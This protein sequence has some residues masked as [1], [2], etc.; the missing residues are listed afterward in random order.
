MANRLSEMGETAMSPSSSTDMTDVDM[1]SIAE[2]ELSEKFSVQGIA[3]GKT[4]GKTKIVRI[5]W[6]SSSAT[7]CIFYI[8]FV[9]MY[10]CVRVQADETRENGTNNNPFNSNEIHEYM[11]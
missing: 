4:S 11:L 2:D 10:A 5:V 8:Y 7:E 1:A 6:C 9:G 3:T